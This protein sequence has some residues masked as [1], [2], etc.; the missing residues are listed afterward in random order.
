MEKE[1][2][3]SN[4]V[5]F[6]CPVVVSNFIDNNGVPSF[7]SNWP[8][9]KSVNKVSH[10]IENIVYE[11]VDKKY[12]NAVAVEKIPS[13][14]ESRLDISKARN[15]QSLSLSLTP[16]IRLG[17]V[18]KKVVSFDLVYTLSTVASKSY[19]TSAVQSSVLSSGSWYKFAIDTTGVFKIDYN[20][21]KDLGISLDGLNPKNIKIYGNGGSMLPQKNEDS[22]IDDLQENSIFVSGEEDG[23]F[24]QNDYV[25]FYGK[26][27]HDWK[28]ESETSIEHR[29]NIYSDKAY[30]FLNVDSGLGMRLSES[31]NVIGVATDF[32]TNFKD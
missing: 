21:L 7:S 11:K 23:V 2:Q 4:G 8:V 14:I 16:M 17:G 24:N 30:Y 15:D 6:I 3:F 9:S 27:P 29:K 20:F 19:R 32:I 12:L 5:R 25:L 28:T 1:I 13:A 18:V 10:T 26:G 31:V 22:R